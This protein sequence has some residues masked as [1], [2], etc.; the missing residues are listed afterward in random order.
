MSSGL[1]RGSEE[2]IFF[3]PWQLDNHPGYIK[4]FMSSVRYGPITGQ[5]ADWQRIAERLNAQK[6]SG[7]E[8]HEREGL[9]NG[10]VLIIAGHKDAIVATDELVEDATVVLGENNVRFEFVDA[11]H[12]LAVSKSKEVLDLISTFWDV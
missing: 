10:K 6:A 1:Q 8:E 7:E 4:S 2:L 3:Q 11:G 5:H 12:D 9:Q